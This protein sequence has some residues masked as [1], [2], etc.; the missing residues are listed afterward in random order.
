MCIEKKLLE[1]ITVIIK[2]R[3]SRDIFDIGHKTQMKT[4]KPIN[5]ER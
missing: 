1:K 2:N 5:M 3:Q 4:N